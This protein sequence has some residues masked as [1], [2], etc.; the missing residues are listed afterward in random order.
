MKLLF[1]RKG[2][3]EKIQDVGQA[4]DSVQE[5]QVHSP[6]LAPHFNP[7]HQE[8]ELSSEVLLEM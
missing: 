8:E 6:T 2:E 5:E 7:H 1:I 3:A 4:P